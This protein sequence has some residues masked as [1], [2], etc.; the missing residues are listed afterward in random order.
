MTFSDQNSVNDYMSGYRF[1]DQTLY[2]GIDW[3]TWT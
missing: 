1:I 2:A 3:K